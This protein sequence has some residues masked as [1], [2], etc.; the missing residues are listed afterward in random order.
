MSSF[1]TPVRSTPDSTDFFAAARE[2][3]LLLR[4]CTDCGA[5]RA[6]QAPACPSCHASAHST[7]TAEGN[8]TLVTWSVVHRSPLPDVT[9]PY[10][11]GAVETEEGPWLLLRLLC[12][13]D[14]VLFTGQAI[15]YVSAS[16]GEDG[17]SVIAGV[18]AGL[19]APRAS[20]SH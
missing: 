20:N 6:P 4:R 18:P 3:R 8:G 9:G 17:E 10:I 11:V 19:A 5:V 16:T 1:P 12:P 2:S 7:I 15:S 14:S 13:I